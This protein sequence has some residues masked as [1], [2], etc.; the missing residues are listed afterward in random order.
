V[1]IVRWAL[2]DEGMAV[3]DYKAPSNAEPEPRAAERAIRRMKK[4]DL[5][6]EFFDSEWIGSQGVAQRAAKRILSH[7]P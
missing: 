4:N 6:R 7:D 3:I 5:H 1:D 2:E